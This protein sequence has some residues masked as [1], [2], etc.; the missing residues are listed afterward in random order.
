MSSYSTLTY[1]KV[2]TYLFSDPSLH[3]KFKNFF[4]SW[5]KL[6]YGTINAYSTTNN[7]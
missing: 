1:T 5:R 4:S 2:V 3:N 7:I 6:D